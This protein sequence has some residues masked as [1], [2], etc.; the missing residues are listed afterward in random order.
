MQIEVDL[1]A[2]T[3][4]EQIT[5]HIVESQLGV[6]L[7]EKIEKF[8]SSTG[9]YRSS[10]PQMLEAAVEDVVRKTIVE[11]VEA[12]YTEAIKAEVKRQMTEEVLRRAVCHII[13]TAWQHH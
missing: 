1:S 7:K 11:E 2:S 12:T 10:F 6:A 13:E 8:L 9:G 4:N 5:R 3:L